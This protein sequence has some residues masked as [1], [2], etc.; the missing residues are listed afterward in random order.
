MVEK[1]NHFPVYMWAGPGTIRI[2]KVKFPATP[3]DEK[4]HMEGGLRIGAKRLRQMGYNW[5]YCT[6]NWGFPP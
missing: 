1:W 4:V 6:Y 3:I 2:N 5:A